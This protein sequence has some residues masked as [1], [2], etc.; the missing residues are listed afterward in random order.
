MNIKQSMNDDASEQKLN[1]TIMKEIENRVQSSIVKKFAI[2]DDKI[3]K[4]LELI[5]K[6]EQTTC[7]E[8]NEIK[9]LL[10][11][12]RNES[13]TCT[14]QQTQTMPVASESDEERVEPRIAKSFDLETSLSLETST[15]STKTII[16]SSAVHAHD[17]STASYIHYKDKLPDPLKSYV[18]KTNLSLNTCHISLNPTI[19]AAERS[20]PTKAMRNPPTKH[21]QASSSASDGETKNKLAG[22]QLIKSSDC[23]TGAEK[24]KPTKTVLPRH[25]MDT[26]SV[27]SESL[28]LSNRLRLDKSSAS[29]PSFSLTSSETPLS[30][31]IL[32]TEQSEPTK[33]MPNPST[34]HAQDSSSDTETKRAASEKIYFSDSKTDV[35]HEISQKFSSPFVL[36]ASS[37]F[38]LAAEISKSTKTVFKLPTEHGR[39]SASVASHSSQ[40]TD[41]PQFTKPRS[42]LEP[43]LLRALK[44]L[45]VS[46]ATSMPS[47]PA[48]TMSQAAAP[49]KSVSS[50]KENRRR[51]LN[52]QINESSESSLTVSKHQNTNGAVQQKSQEVVADLSICHP[53]FLDL[54][55]SNTSTVIKSSV[56]TGTQQKLVRDIE[57][58][59]ANE[60]VLPSNPGK[61]DEYNSVLSSSQPE[62]YEG[63]FDFSTLK[64]SAT[65]TPVRRPRP[66]PLPRSGSKNFSITNINVP[67]VNQ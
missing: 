3:D 5:D 20:Q 67:S 45:N 16:E 25:T 56:I 64:I 28:D 17:T 43:S 2:M 21:G 61:K 40:S 36:A 44:R 26:L 48:K 18:S 47:E 24:S 55:E 53:E 51:N 8:L 29:K 1:Q 12:V 57:N 41:A 34:A 50:I 27:A 49:V 39:L 38:V 46:K 66:V 23:N 35:P 31:N 37:P 30:S 62:P 11:Q 14:S 52:E 33:T 15:T 65:S 7:T 6:L 32:A 10:Y 59:T 13:R 42:G 54:S 9:S 19:L 4:V 63:L 60:Y 58:K 22:P